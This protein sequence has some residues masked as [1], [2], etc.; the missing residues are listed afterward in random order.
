MIKKKKLQERIKEAR[1]EALTL[2]VCIQDPRVHWFPKAIIWLVAMYALSPID[3][4]PDFI[5]YIGY[6]DDMLILPIGTWV[7]RNMVHPD[8]LADAQRKMRL[9]K[10][11][12]GPITWMFQVIITIAWLALAVFI[13][14]KI[15]KAILSE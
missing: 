13:A 10:V 1:L 3:I 8:V 11:K 14:V 7:A 12:E 15:R 9:V 5:P 4:I 6:L 2:Y